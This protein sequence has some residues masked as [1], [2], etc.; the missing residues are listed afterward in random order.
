MNKAF[1]AKVTKSTFKMPKWMECS[2]RRQECGRKSCKICSRLQ[3][4]RQR[5]LDAGEDPDDMAVVFEDISL[6]FKETLAAIKRD[7]ERLGIDITNIDHIQE[8][9]RPE[10]FSLYRKVAAWRHSMADLLEGAD[11]DEEIWPF[12]DEGQDLSWYKNTLCAKVYR[13]LT[14]RWHLDSDDDYGEFDYEY[15]QY[16]L[17]ECLKILKAS[18]SELIKMDLRHKPQFLI[19]LANLNTLESKILKI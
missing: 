3:K 5:H 12:T 17:K 9:P 6:A 2:W 11:L 4:D 1:K 14:N 8:P 15:T 13:Q 7:A 10:K 18:L 16:V 19:A